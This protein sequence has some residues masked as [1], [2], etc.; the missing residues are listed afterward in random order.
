M[1]KVISALLM[2]LML[3]SSI[4]VLAY[5]PI[6]V[7]VN[8]RKLEFD[9]APIN[10][11]G[12]VL[13]PVRAIF[14]ALGADIIWNPQ[15]ETITSSLNGTTV[16][17]TIGSSMMLVNNKPVFTDVEPMIVADR[18]LVP[19]RAISEALGSEVTWDADS[20]T[21]KIYT[22]DF[23]HY[24]AYTDTYTT[25]KNLDGIY[26]GVNVSYFGAYHTVTN[27]ADGTDFKTYCTSDSYHAEINI[28]T[29]V[30]TGAPLPMTAAYAQSLATSVANVV[31]GTATYG[32]ITNING[33][34]FI[35]A[36][37]Y[38]LASSPTM[39]EVQTSVLYHTTSHNGIMYTM[40]YTS[41]G[42]VPA[43]V[44]SHM[45]YILSTMVI[46]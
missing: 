6:T 11:N 25:S 16:V 43:D 5:S 35:E 27:S 28:R 42:N 21:V 17:M 24:S 18:T 41:Y 44:D 34:N 36:H 39:G 13:V 15:I 31:H 10:Q 38:G 3:F 20:N 22:E 29:D 7:E 9:V 19:V 8:A 4:S 32:K 14:E 46:H 12:R 26:S 30:Y 37:Y 2:V 33:R 1:K 45:N 40:T 23:I